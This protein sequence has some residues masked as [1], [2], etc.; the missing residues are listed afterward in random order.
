MGLRSTHGNQSQAFVPLRRRGSTWIPAKLVLRESG[1]AG[2]QFLSDMDPHFRG[3]DALPVISLRGPR[4][5]RR[6][7]LTS[8]PQSSPRC[9]AR[10][11]FRKTESTACLA[12]WVH[13]A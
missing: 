10:R 3:G 11:V 1:G 4:V 9:L 12:L 5:A 7:P 2:I 6:S 13:W 8:A